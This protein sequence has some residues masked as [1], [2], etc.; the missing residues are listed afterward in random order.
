MSEFYRST[1]TSI[2]AK[3]KIFL[4]S[5]ACFSASAPK[6]RS[7]TEIE[8][9]SCRS[10]SSAS[11]FSAWSFNSSN[12]SLEQLKD[13]YS[14]LRSSQNVYLSDS[15]LK[16]KPIHCPLK[17]LTATKFCFKLVS[18][19]K[20]SGISYSKVVSPIRSLSLKKMMGGTITD[21]PFK[22]SPYVILT[23]LRVP[24]RPVSVHFL[25]PWDVLVINILTSS[26]SFVI[27]SSSNG[28]SRL[29]TISVSLFPWWSQ[30]GVSSSPSN[31]SA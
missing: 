31:R 30:S 17:T 10:Y 7:L 27:I 26:K 9:A 4:N 15:F 19:L 24:S 25:F 18:N 13:F 29:R 14:S 8:S 6:S 23:R 22:I 16:W 21:S 2:P 20:F 3:I 28:F 1:S 12:Y 11:N 5:L